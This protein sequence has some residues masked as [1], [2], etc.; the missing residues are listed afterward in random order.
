MQ[1]EF[2]QSRMI[3]GKWESYLK[4]ELVA[5][6]ITDSDLGTKLCMWRSTILAFCIVLLKGVSKFLNF[7]WADSVGLKINWYG[8][9]EWRSYSRSSVRSVSINLESMAVSFA[10]TKSRVLI[11]LAFSGVQVQTLPQK[12]Q[13]AFFQIHQLL[14]E[15]L[16]QLMRGFCLVGWSGFFFLLASCTS[17]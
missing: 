9:N 7:D 14:E 4:W 5:W 15:H 2:P 16:W 1:N 11:L 13:N 12:K 6:T 17:L 8:W 10:S 3:C